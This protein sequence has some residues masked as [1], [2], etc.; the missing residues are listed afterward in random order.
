MEAISM[1]AIESLIVGKLK[2]FLKSHLGE[3]IAK[4]IVIIIKMSYHQGNCVEI[5]RDLFY[6]LI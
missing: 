5:R 2:L 3:L 4:S 1:A 6:P